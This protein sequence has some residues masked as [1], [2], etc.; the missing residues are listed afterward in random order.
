MEQENK[1]DD[2]LAR[3]SMLDFT[4]ETPVKKEKTVEEVLEEFPV[5]NYDYG[6]AVY[7]SRKFPLLPDEAFEVLEE[8]FLMK[9][10]K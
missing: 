6:S 7:F 10:T 5:L 1:I 2:V 3:F 4:D 9:T 8:N